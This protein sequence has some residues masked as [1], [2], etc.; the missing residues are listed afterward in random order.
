M[1]ILH[2]THW[3]ERQLNCIAEIAKAG[4]IFGSRRATLKEITSRATEHQKIETPTNQ[5]EQ[6]S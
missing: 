5:N 1:N 6:Q 3:L 2:Y 4:N